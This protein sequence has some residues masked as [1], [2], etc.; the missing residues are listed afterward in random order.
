MKANLL[1]P[2]LTAN[3]IS[4]E[5]VN[6]YFE[7]GDYIKAGTDLVEFGTSKA[8]VVASAESSGY[9]NRAK[10]KGEFVRTGEVYAVLFASQ[11]DAA[12]ASAAKAEAPAFPMAARFSQ[13]AQDYAREKGFDLAGFKASGLITKNDLAAHFEPHLSEKLDRRKFLE[14]ENLTAGNEGALLSRLHLQ[15]SFANK[16]GGLLPLVIRESARLLTRFPKLAAWFSNGQ[17]HYYPDHHIGVAV[18]G[19]SGLKVLTVRDPAKL[20]PPQIAEALAALTLSEMRSELTNEDLT[21]SC[22]T[23]TDLSSLGILYF[24]PLLNGHQSAILGLGGD[25]ASPSQPYSFNLTFDHRVLSGR[26]AAEFLNELKKRVA[27]LES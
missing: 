8:T 12:A 10:L 16:G 7:D 6:W 17:I 2:K 15:F 4:I 5:I 21:G 20:T 14:I 24:D 25:A 22:F 23:I 18:D 9:L 19:G 3:D 1:T 13:R 11:A 26:E 27:G